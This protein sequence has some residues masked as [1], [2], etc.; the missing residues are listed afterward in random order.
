MK[1]GLSSPENLVIRAKELNQKAIAVSDHGNIYALCEFQDACNKH[2]VKPIFGTEFYI[3]PNNEHKGENNH[4]CIYAKNTNGLVNIRKMTSIASLENSYKGK[5]RLTPEI[6]LNNCEDIVITFACLGSCFRKEYGI[7]MLEDLIGKIGVDDIYVEYHCNFW[8]GQDEWNLEQRAI[9]EKYNLK[10]IVANDVHYARRED[11]KTHEVLLCLSVLAWD[12]S[13]TMKSND[14]WTFECEEHYMKSGNEILDTFKRMKTKLSKTSVIEAIKNTEE[15]ANKCNVIIEEKKFALPQTRAC[16]ESGLSEVEYYNS[17][18]EKGLDKYVY[19]LDSFT[20]LSENDKN[21]RIKIHRE[22][23]ERE[24]EVII[25]KGFVRYF[26]LVHDIY[27]FCER[28]DIAVGIGRGSVSGSLHAYLLGMSKCLNPIDNGLLFERFLNSEQVSLPDID[29]DCSKVD[30]NKIISYVKSEYGVDNVAQ[31]STFT[32]L[33]FKG[34]FKSVCRAFEI[35]PQLSNKLVKDIPDTLRI[36][37]FDDITQFNELRTFLDNNEMIKKHTFSLLGC[38]SNT[39]MHAGAVLI[40]DEPFNDGKRCSLLDVKGS[41]VIDLDKKYAEFNGCLKLD[42]LGLA[43]ADVIHNTFKSIHKN[44]GVKYIYETVPL[45]DRKTFDTL[46]NGIVY[47]VNQFAGYTAKNVTCRMGVDS[48]D[49]MVV[50]SSI[51][52]PGANTDQIIDT[53]LSGKR[54]IY[55]NVLDDILKSTYGAIF[56]QETAM[57]VFR[58]CAGMDEMKVDELRRVISKSKGQVVMNSYKGEFMEGCRNTKVIKKI[59][60]ERVW[61]EILLCSDYSFC[62]GHAMSYTMTSYISA[63]LKCHYPSE[64]YANVLTYDGKNEAEVMREAVNY[65]KLNLQLPKIG[66]SKA[67]EWVGKD[68][69]LFAPFKSIKNVGDRLAQEIEDYKEPKN[70]GFFFDVGYDSSGLPEKAIKILDSVHAFDID[71]RFTRT[72]L[73]VMDCLFGFDTLLLKH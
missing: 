26:L 27:E 54:H 19:E 33:K 15:I 21:E 47:G 36:K 68:G 46:T 37:T 38:I 5:P 50:I 70:Q 8:D 44:H 64:F 48:F 60:A 6:L 51:A 13:K 58:V 34:S 49:D 32:Y 73:K 3:V 9:A 24:S 67:F 10:A 45:N 72:D 25:G 28:T 30:R 53:K 42:L 71:Y 11:V 7:N 20:S 35:D 52:R 63:W 62:K 1:D 65:F 56:L 17:L 41:I 43:Q 61:K 16:K 57:E 40:S 22:R 4:I 66:V 14:R 2:D 18:L 31:L 59:D 55:G 23:I 39:S 12:K 29:F 69:G